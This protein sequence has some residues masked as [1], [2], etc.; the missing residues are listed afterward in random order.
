[1]ALTRLD[2]AIPER[3][4]AP[5][6]TMAQQA[7]EQGLVTVNGITA[8][9][10]SQPI[11]DTDTVVVSALPHDYVGR[12]G[13]K[14]NHALDAFAIEVAGLTVLDVGASTGGFTD[15]LLRRGAAH[16]LACDIGIDQLHPTLRADSRVAVMERTDV[17]T[18]TLTQP[19]ELLTCDVSMLSLTQLLPH[20]GRLCAATA[21]AVLLVKPQYET[22]KS[23][24]NK[25]GV[26]KTA[27]ARQQALD[28]VL[29]AA[30]ANG[31]QVLATLPS[32]VAGGDGNLEYL[33]HI[34]RREVAP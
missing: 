13:L 25:H 7:I 5:S 11:E 31:W 22:S 32:P 33:L 26:V 20:F 21:Q 24:K 1:M 9:K 3:G 16:V 2:R 34:A 29:T 23:Q 4:L 14:L 30:Q 8:T 15:C 27:Q 28:R 10:A 12:G 19:V 17:R 6:R 18:L